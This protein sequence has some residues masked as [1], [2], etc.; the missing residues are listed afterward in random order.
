MELPPTRLVFE[1]NLQGLAQKHVTVRSALLV[2]NA[3][4][5][6]VELKLENTIVYPSCKYYSWRK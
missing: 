5:D 2:K 1:V 4:P 3:L 6:P